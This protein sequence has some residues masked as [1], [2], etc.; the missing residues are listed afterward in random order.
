MVR[1]GSVEARYSYIG[2]RGAA[3]ANPGRRSAYR[4]TRNKSGPQADRSS[5]IPDP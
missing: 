1:A 3:D 4:L 2:E 5:G